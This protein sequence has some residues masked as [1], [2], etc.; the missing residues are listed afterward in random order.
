VFH[1]YDIILNIAKTDPDLF[2]ANVIAALTEL[3][4]IYILVKV[5]MGLTNKQEKIA[6]IEAQVDDIVAA[7]TITLSNEIIRLEE[8]ASTDHLTKIPNRRELKKAITDEFVRSARSQRKFA[9]IMFDLDH[10]KQVNDTYGHDMG[11]TVLIAVAKTVKAMVRD[12]DT[13]GRYGGEEFLL[14]LPETEI[15]QATELAERIRIAIEHIVVGAGK[16][17][18]SIGVTCSGES[19]TVAD[20]IRAA[21]EAMYDAKSEGRNTV[22][23]YTK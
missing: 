9:L 23:K 13:F 6:E 4:T 8:I 7:R 22:C 12:L 14:V 5:S 10:F 21:D 2:V 11:D 15:Y 17:T 18:A 16:I 1:H 19:T 20:M 3:F